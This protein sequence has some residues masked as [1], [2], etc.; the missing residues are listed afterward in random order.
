[1]TEICQ[2]RIVV[3]PN[4]AAPEWKVQAGEL[5]EEAAPRYSAELAGLMASLHD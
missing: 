1:V 2:F 3:S 4:T 5:D